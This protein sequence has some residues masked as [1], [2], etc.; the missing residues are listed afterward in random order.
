MNIIEFPRNENQPQGIE[1][2]EID[3]NHV[4]VT[5]WFDEYALWEASVRITDEMRRQLI[6]ALM[7]PEG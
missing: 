1:S 7:W 2:I 5:G 6:S 4:T 3:G